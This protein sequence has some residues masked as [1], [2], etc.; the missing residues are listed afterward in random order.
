[1]EITFQRSLWGYDCREVDQ[2]ITQLNNNLAAKF[3]AKEKERDELAGIN[4]KMKETLKEAQSEIKQY[5]MEEKAVADVIIQA[6]LQAAA[7]EK[8][9]RSQA[10]EQVQAVLTEIEFKRR[11]LI[12]LQNHY[13]NVKDNLMQ[14][15]NKYK[16]L[17]EE[18]Q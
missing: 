6:Q 3:K 9:A 2:F 16:I 12:S 10:E 5:Q 8:K 14:V 11:E 15:I 13:N 7:I 4:V 17:L 1:M 18:H